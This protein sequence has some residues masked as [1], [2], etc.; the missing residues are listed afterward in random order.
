[1]SKFKKLDF[2][3]VKTY[4]LARRKSK[5]STDDFAKVT[6]KNPDFKD[7]LNSL[8]NIL[9]GKQFLEFINLYTKAINSNSQILMMMVMV[10]LFCMG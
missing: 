7:F 3:N 2:S 9:S 1:M 8:P 5:V 10:F 6:T 4:D